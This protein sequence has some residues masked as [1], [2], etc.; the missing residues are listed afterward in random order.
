M[1]YLFRAFERKQRE[2][3]VMNN[4]F[5]CHNL[6]RF[7]KGISQYI[8]N[9]QIEIVNK[10]ILEEKQMKRRYQQQPQLWPDNRPR[11]GLGIFYVFC[12]LIL[13]NY[14]HKKLINSLFNC[15]GFHARGPSLVLL[16][17]V[18]LNPWNMVPMLKTLESANYLYYSLQFYFL[19]IV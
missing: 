1:I 14:C 8:F 9:L 12:W 17:R 4:L 3:E 2:Q 7:D 10:V 5:L 6:Q 13:K 11:V 18:D 16:H 19:G 15:R